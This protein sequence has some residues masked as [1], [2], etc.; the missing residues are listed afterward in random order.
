MERIY[1]HRTFG[2]IGKVELVVPEGK[3]TLDGKELPAVS[4]AA[5][6][7]HSLQILQDAYA[8]AKN[9]DEA[10]G[11]F[12]AK[13]DNLVNG[14]IGQRGGSA[15][16]KEDQA[17]INLVH[18]AIK[19]GDD[20]DTWKAWQAMGL[21]EQLET[22]QKYADDFADDL[23]GEIARMDEEAERKAVEAERAAKLADKVKIKL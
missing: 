21:T 17:L 1:T 7:R 6:V 19:K 14:T 3:W 15:L 10:L 23:A 12:G 8:G 11:A 22:A 4:V 16:A 9:K 5:F 20:K 18:S 13:Y 2:Q